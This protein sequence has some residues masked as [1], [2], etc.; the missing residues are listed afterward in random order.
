MRSVGRIGWRKP[1]FVAP[2]LMGEE[3]FGRRMRAHLGRTRPI[4]MMQRVMNGTAYETDLTR[5]GQQ[6]AKEIMALQPTGPYHLLGYSF[7][8]QVAFSTAVALQQA[9][10]KVAFVGI[11][12]EDADVHRRIF[13]IKNAMVDAQ[14]ILAAG[15]QAIFANPLLHF[16]GKVTLFRARIWS[17]W[18]APPPALDWEFLAD[19]GVDV[20]NLD[21]AHLDFPSS[22][23]MQ[24]WAPLLRQELA[25]CGGH[26]LYAKRKKPMFVASRCDAV[27]PPAFEA[28]RMAQVGDREAEIALYTQALE[29][30]PQAP[31]WVRINLANAYLY[32]MNDP[33]RAH[34]VLRPCLTTQQPALP[35]HV[36]AVNCLNA[37]GDRAQTEAF[38]TSCWRLDNRRASDWITLGVVM[39]WGHKHADAQKAFE[40][41][42][43]VEPTR[44]DAYKRLYDL[45]RSLDQKDEAEQLVR[46][47]IERG[48]ASVF[49]LTLLGE[50]LLDRGAFTEA[51]SHLETALAEGPFNARTTV[52]HCRVL[53]E[54]GE[55]AQA[56]TL[57]EAG[58]AIE[59]R[60]HRLHI[61]LGE[62]CIKQGLLGEAEENFA[63]AIRLQPTDANGWVALASLYVEQGRTQDLIALRERAPDDVAQTYRFRVAAGLE[64]A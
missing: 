46:N 5:M 4:Y 58:L 40:K 31:D 41:A 61:I 33:I 56:K 37:I 22:S 9:G 64:T 26:F 54:L 3:K 20:F 47:A 43:E 6:H 1:L 11:L 2:G 25:H 29:Q 39:L 59:N 55:I 57:A 21:Y 18:R 10:Q 50:T 52:A 7:G 42:I 15:R 8:G 44:T 28:F 38:V 45:L 17:G 36:V 16:D 14:E 24:D 62:L 32:Q 27:P 13:N 48:Y 19:G 51:R 63:T 60:H 30:N 49:L 53:A 34:E 23:A 12:D 35:Q